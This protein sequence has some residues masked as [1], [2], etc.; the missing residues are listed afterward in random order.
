MIKLNGIWKEGFAFDNHTISSE[1][2]GNDEYGTPRFKTIRTQ[3]GEL[4]YRMK[5]CQDGSQLRAIMELLISDVGFCR[6]MEKVD[7]ILLVPPSN[8]GRMIQPVVYVANEIAT[9]FHKPLNM[10]ALQTSNREQIK[11]LDEQDREGIIN[12][13]AIINVGMLDA[14]KS[15][16]ILDDVY[17]TGSTL[18][19][20]AGRLVQLGVCNLYVFTLTKVRSR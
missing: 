9:Y 19:A 4:L 10:H 8:I 13:S 14:R 3:M 6:L 11:N 7:E 20:Y 12:S 16:I 5:Y 17:D 2:L 15:Y 18:K 1:F